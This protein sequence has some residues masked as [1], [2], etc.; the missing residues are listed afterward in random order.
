MFRQA[1]PAAYGDCGDKAVAKFAPV[2]LNGGGIGAENLIKGLRSKKTN[3]DGHYIYLKF[4]QPVK[5]DFTL[6]TDFAGG[7]TDKFKFRR[8]KRYPYDGVYYLSLKGEDNALATDFS[9]KAHE[10][11]KDF[12]VEGR[13]CRLPDG[14]VSVEKKPFSLFDMFKKDK[15][16]DAKKDKKDKKRDKKKD[17]E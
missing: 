17:G 8:S 13:I 5:K 15:D 9:I 16:K 11:M 6:I 4:N 10:D 14:K 2:K 1:V 3:A 7:K 12:T